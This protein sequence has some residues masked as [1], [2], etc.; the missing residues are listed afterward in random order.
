MLARTSGDSAT[1]AESLRRALQ[2]SYPGVPYLTVMPLADRVGRQSRSWSLGAT[3]FTIFGS[4]ALLVA[5]LGLYSVV[6]FTLAERHR[7]FGVLVALGATSTDLIRSAVVRGVLP[8]A[9]GIGLGLLIELLASPSTSGTAA[10]CLAP[11]SAGLCDRSPRPPHRIGSGLS[12]PVAS[13]EPGGSDGGAA[14]GVGLCSGT[15]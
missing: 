3:M 8:A 12:G 4:L 7:E 10:G 9:G 1:L 13:V 2:A 14:R 5:V 11:G 15:A 6:R